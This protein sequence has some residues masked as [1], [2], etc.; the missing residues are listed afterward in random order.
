[1]NA[2]YDTI[3]AGA[4]E[5]SEDSRVTLV[6]RLLVSLTPDVALQ[7]EHLETVRG[8][9]AEIESGSVQPVSGESVAADVRRAVLQARGA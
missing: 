5:L 2:T 6:E 8:R 4:L 9:K 7:R 3:L 1:M